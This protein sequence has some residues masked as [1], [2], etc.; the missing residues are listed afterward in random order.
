MILE[1]LRFQCL[2]Y[3][4]SLKNHCSG[5]LIYGRQHYDFQEGSLMFI[6]PDQVFSTE[7]EDSME[8]EIEGWGLYF[9]PDLIRHT[10]LMGKMKGYSFFGYDTH[11]ALHVSDE[12]KQTITQVVKT[13]EHEF[14]QNLDDHSQTL[15]ISNIELL[16]N[17]C[18]RFYSRQFLTRTTASKDVIIRF[19]EFLEAYFESDQIRQNGM[20]SVKYCAQQ[21][22]Y[23]ANYLSDMLKKETNKNTQEHI[24]SV[25]IE[26]AKNMLLGTSESVSQ[27]AYQLGFEYPQHFSKLFKKK[28]GVAPAEFR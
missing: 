19:E 3:S 11:E 24:H 16:L 21:M 12:E 15:I 14:S 23:S 18:N 22:G 28:T 6:A 26:K 7:G 25:L 17:Y 9:H 1:A 27:I 2:F 4:I 20:P 13:I 8:R 5:K 10:D